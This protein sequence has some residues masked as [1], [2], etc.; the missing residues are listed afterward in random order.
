MAESRKSMNT[1]DNKKDVISLRKSRKSIN[2]GR[3]TILLP[4]RPES[5]DL[6]F[7]KE[8]KRTP[9]SLQMQQTNTNLPNARLSLPQTVTTNTQK[10]S[11]EEIKKM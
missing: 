8:T 3:Q 5:H 1:K 7:V 4:E 2:D 9:Q 10:Q 6:R 11:I